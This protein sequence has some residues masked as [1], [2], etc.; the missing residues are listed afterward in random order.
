MLCTSALG[1]SI[2][3]GFAAI[4]D[5]PRIA[6]QQADQKV[7]QMLRTPDPVL[8]LSRGVDGPLGQAIRNAP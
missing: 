4:G 6:E 7:A 3:V 2:V 8:S 1:L 5:R